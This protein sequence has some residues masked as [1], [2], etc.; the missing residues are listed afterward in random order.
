MRPGSLLPM[1]VA[2]FITLIITL[3][4]VDVRS[5][6]DPPFLLPFLNSIF[7]AVIPFF[8]SFTAARLF[9]SAGSVPLL[10]LG[11][12]MLA[13]GSGGLMSGGFIGY[14]GGP[15]ITVTIFNSSALLSSLLLLF[16][17]IMP[18]VSATW[19]PF[20]NRVRSLF[21]LYLGVLIVAGGIMYLGTSCLMPDFIIPGKGP[22]LPGRSVLLLT[23]FSFGSSAVLSLRQYHKSGTEPLRWYTTG[24]L[25]ITIGLTGVLLQKIVGSP[26]GWAGRISQFTG[27]VCILIGTLN[28]WK[29][30]VSTGLSFGETIEERTESLQQL[31]NQQ[32][33]ILEGAG[34][35][36]ALINDHQMR[37]KLEQSHNLLTSLSRQIPGMIYQFQLFP[38]GRSCFPY[39]SDAIIDMYE[40]TPDEVREDATPLFNKLHP[41][42]SAMVS[43]TIIDSARTLEPWEYDFRVNLPQQGVQWRHGF[44]HPQRLNDGSTLWHG[45]VNDI[46]ARKQLEFELADARNTADIANRAKS[47]FLANMSHEIRTPMNGLLGMTQLLGMTDLTPEQREYVTALKLS[48]TNLLSLVNDILD[49]SKIEAGSMI[50]EPAEFNLRRAI[51]DVYLMQKSSIFQRK[52][53]FAVTIAEDIPTEIIGDQLRVKQIIHNLLGNAAKFTKQGGISIAAQ[54]HERLPGSIIIQISVTDSGIGISAE[55]LDQIFKPFVQ[56]DGSTTRQFGGTGLGLTI[57]RRL[58]EI[59]GGSISVDST[60]SVGSRFIVKLPFTIPHTQNT[61]EIPSETTSPFWDGPSLR[62]LVVEDNPLSLKFASGLLGKHGHRLVTA[63]N[64]REC[65]E[66]L[67]QGSFDLVLMDIQMP[68]MNG[69]EALHAI[70]AQEEGTS[71]HQKIIA[72]TAHALRFEQE[73]FLSEG[74]DGYLSKPVEQHE[75]IDEMKRVLDL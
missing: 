66:A 42:D 73:R 31:A 25:L 12:G 28:F 2:C 59:M 7:L 57:S 65:L 15:N 17:E 36:I 9:L 6:F 75:L 63:E 58:A 68:V 35:D 18:S 69:E 34:V 46:S 70:R 14:A 40:V 10:L 8:I 50:I 52:L 44:A 45:F 71:C 48:G 53:T 54:V 33:A 37:I 1:L 30:K 51:D 64:G 72:V 74:F 47:Q 20:S 5:S 21:A 56:G 60:L 13:L 4:V 24:L 11:S 43:E 27:S 67:E 26:I 41:D 49:L 39:A 29:L 32:S 16:S 19:N 61:A 23:I 22:T 62:I 55:A 38:D 3:F